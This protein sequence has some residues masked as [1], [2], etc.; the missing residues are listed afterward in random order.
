M[1]TFRKANSIP[2]ENNL[3]FKRI[4]FATFLFF[5]SPGFCQQLIVSPYLQP[6]NA[7]SL[8]R[9]EKTLIWQT[10]SVS[11]VY[12][13][14]Y[15]KGAFMASEKPWQAKI[16]FVKLQLNKKTTFL[17]RAQLTKLQF[18]EVYSYRL[19]LNG[20]TVAEGSFQS[21]SKKPITRFAVFGDCGQKT[22]EQAQIA[23]Q[24]SQ[25]KPQ[26]VLV[27]GDNVYQN[28][29]QGEYI[30]NFFPYYMAPEPSPTTGASLI[31]N[32]PFYMV[33]G[34]HD[35]HGAN[36]TK[37]PAGLAYFYYND[38]PLNAP[39]PES[40]I[41]ATGDADLV[42]LFKKNTSPRFPRI[43][44]Y[45]FDYGNV[46]ITCLDANYYVNPLDPALIEWL[47]S[48]LHNSKADWKIVSYHQPGFNSS[49]AHYDDQIMRLLSHV[50]EELG[51]DLVLSGHVHSYQRTVPLKF[52]PKKNK[53]GTQ[54]II[55]KE[56]RVDGS[57][58]LDQQYDGVTKTKPNGIIYVVSG[59]G[60]APLFDKEL[61]G[62]PELWK[63]N[64]PEN[65]VPFTVKMISD[66]HSFT[67]IETNS[68]KLI[69]KQ[70]DVNG[71]VL[72]EI[73]VTR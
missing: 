30:T 33:I 21:R 16:A 57:F 50:L 13:V 73:T 58:T 69:L 25:Q 27:T 40:T 1:D 4:L 48:D 19:N 45:S 3:P 59:A 51:V 20:K 71:Q 26:F 17:Y 56:G 18:D 47:T 28:G 34:N 68:K 9:E 36:L 65:W 62:N 31:N 12:E 39:I 41:E 46:H 10:D 29:L 7:P 14:E 22:P 44:N 60:G 24:V 72:D 70:M 42:K 32:L 35:I 53:E 61:N 5:W 55:S 11:G 66:R 23:Y 2:F 43:A 52:S 64:L 67:L 15:K 6:G 38:L 63:H 8:S 54:Y 49:K 37:F